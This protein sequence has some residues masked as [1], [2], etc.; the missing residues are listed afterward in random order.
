MIDFALIIRLGKAP[1][2]VFPAVRADGRVIQLHIARYG[3]LAVAQQVFIGHQKI[4]QPLHIAGQLALHALFRI[5]GKI[6]IRQHVVAIAQL[7]ARA[8]GSEHHTIQQPHSGGIKAAFGIAVVHI[9]RHDQRLSA[10]LLTGIEDRLMDAVIAIVGKAVAVLIPGPELRI[11][12]IHIAD[13]HIF[14]ALRADRVECQIF[15]GD[16]RLCGV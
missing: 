16:G 2:G 6:L 5:G 13:V 11:Q 14:N 1:D 9:R 3:P 12:H 10:A 4:V 15:G 7:D 8:A